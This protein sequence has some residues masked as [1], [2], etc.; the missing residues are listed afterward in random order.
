LYDLSKPIPKV[1]RPNKAEHEKE[2][3]DIQKEVDSIKEERTKLQEKIDAAM[4]GGK[5]SEIG[6]LKEASGQLRKKK[7]A[8]IDEKKVIRAKLDIIKSQGD[9]MVKERKEARSSVRFTNLAD[10]DKELARLQKQQETTSMSLA[11][12]K[13][14]IKEMDTLKGAK[15]SISK[16][17]EKETGLEDIKEQ[18]KIIS[19]QINAKDKE[20][21][22]VQKD[23]DE[24][25]SKIKSMA[26]QETEAR[27]K[28]KELF[29]KRDECRKNFND[30]LKKKDALRAAFREQNNAW[31]NMQRAVKAQK[32]IEYEKE[33]KRRE[34]EHAAWQKKKEEEEAK[35]IP[36]EEEM[37]LCEYL[38]NYLT[39]TYLTDAEAAKRE[40]AAALE[41]KRK[42]DVVAVQ[43]NHFAN[44]KPVI[45]N[46]EDSVYFGKGK[47][48]KKRDRASKKKEKAVAGPFRLNVDTFEQFGLLSLDPPTGLDQVA[49]S[50]EELK[51]KKKWYSEQERG[52]VPTA[53]DIRKANQQAAAKLRQRNAPKGKKQES[54]GKFSLANDEFVPLGAGGSS[55]LNA[56]WG[57]K[58][59]AAEEEETP[60]VEE[61]EEEAVAENGE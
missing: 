35:K 60:A 48:K 22:A 32:Q 19:A 12:E 41:A 2:L 25:Q 50:V 52:A 27:E 4:S 18:R 34:E 55:S 17:K 26:S 37:A 40:A 7:G 33:K 5:G 11:D 23:I 24:I 14:L 28:V 44:F 43:D 15:D 1:D 42:A 61:E 38:A 56:N 21:D 13:R 54:G 57:Q 53:T 6:K 45:K 3:D 47:G 36:Y 16:I 10:I 29:T 8:L 49:K 31:Y 51:A 58:P 30:L 59:A 20:I 9:K 46:E 39:K